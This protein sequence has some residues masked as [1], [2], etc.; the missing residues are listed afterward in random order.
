MLLV[1]YK[2]WALDIL[3][4]RLASYDTV[5]KICQLDCDA[6]SA[7]VMSATLYFVRAHLY[8]INVKNVRSNVRMNLL[9]MSTLWLTSFGHKST[10]GTNRRTMLANMRNIATTAIAS[11]WLIAQNI[12]I[13]PRYFTT[14]WTA[15]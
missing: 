5:D 4:L 2:D 3:V 7:S 12:V 8:A 15:R 1:R 14:E 13:N 10:L 11:M 9:W 6:G